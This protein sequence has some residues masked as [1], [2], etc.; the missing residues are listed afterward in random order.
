MFGLRGDPIDRIGDI[1]GRDR[2]D[3]LI[4]IVRSTLIAAGGY[5]TAKAE[6]LLAAGLIDA[7]AFG[8]A[9]IANPDLVTRL[10]QGLPL[11][12]VQQATVYGGGAAGYTD[13]PR[14]S[15]AALAG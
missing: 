10:S 2:I 9:F 12:A 14:W 3:A 4:K 8:R 13:Y 1:V 5:D 15:G 6:R 7:V 11:N